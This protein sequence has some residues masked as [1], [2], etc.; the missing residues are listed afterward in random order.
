VSHLPCYISSGLL[1]LLLVIQQIQNNRIT[2]ALHDRI[3]ESK[4]LEPVP[5]VEAI[6]KMVDALLPDRIPYNQGHKDLEKKVREAQMR[7]RFNIPGMPQE[8]AK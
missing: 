4:G 8:K 6:N 1:A 2:A 5:K 3:L 7:V